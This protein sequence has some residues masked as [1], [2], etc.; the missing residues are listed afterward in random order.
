MDL[1]S[2]GS[3]CLPFLP[4]LIV[5]C[6]FHSL[7]SSSFK[8]TGLLYVQA[9]VAFKGEILVQNGILLVAPFTSEP[10]AS[11]LYSSLILFPVLLGWM[12]GRLAWYVTAGL[13]TSALFA[14]LALQAGRVITAV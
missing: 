3:L 9:R 11:S 2:G 6:T 4:L 12:E 5:L 10:C 13:G 7:M 8:T 14:G 1:G